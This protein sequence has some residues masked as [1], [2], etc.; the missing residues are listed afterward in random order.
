MK[1][2]ISVLAVFLP[3]LVACQG[4][5]V[6]GKVVNEQG[7]AVAGATVVLKGSD[8]TTFSDGGG[9]FEFRNT[10]VYDTLVVSAVGYQTQ[11]V[12]NSE[13]GLITVVLERKATSLQE[14]TVST[15]YQT[16]PRER[17][18]GSFTRIDTQH[19][20]QQVSSDVLSRLEAIT[21]GLSVSRR[22][23]SQGQVS[24]RGLSTIRGPKDP[25]VVVDNFPWEGDIQNLNPA[26]VESITVLKDAA[27]ASI[28]GS[29]A[30]NGVIVITTRKG[31]YGQ[32]L[33]VE[34]L[35]ALTVGDKPD[36]MAL[37]TM[38]P[39][40]FVAVER[41]LFSRGYRF[42]DTASTSRPPFSPV[43]EILFRQRRG[44]LTAAEAEAQLAAL[45]GHDVRRDFLEHAYRPPLKQQY[46][47]TLR[48]GSAAAAWALSA[49][50]DHH[51]GELHDAY[52]RLT[53]RLEHTLK[54]S[55]R[56]TLSAGAAYTDTR[57]EG[58]RPGY[59]DVRVKGGV[60]PPYTRL[61]GE[62][63]EAL[64]L[65]ADYRQ[66][67]IDTAGGGR[68]LPW[69]YY[70]LDDWR[71]GHQ[72][73]GGSDL[74][75]H[76]G[77]NY[78]LLSFL[79]LEVKYAYQRGA[80]EQRQH[81][82]EDSYFA[83]DLVNTFSQLN[84]TTGAV[85]YRV[86]RGGILDRTEG[87]L[88]VHNLRGQLNIDRGWGA[89]RLTGIVGAEQRETANRGASS[90]LYG[91]SDDILVSTPV[92]PT[93]TYPTFIRGSQAFIPY[94]Q[95][96]SE[97]LNR[98]VS[99]YGN[100]AW[101]LRERYTLSAS[102]RR[103]ASNLFGVR[104]ID[105]WTPLWSAGGSWLLSGERF[106]RLA[107][108]PLLRLRLT[109]GY[110]G[111]VDPSL[112][113]V[114]TISYGNASPFTLG[115]T[116]QID[117]FYNPDLRW[118]KVRMLNGGLDFRARGGRLW[119]TVE[120]Y[121]KRGVD[122][123]G[124][125]PL[126]V[127]VGVGKTT[128]IKNVASM[129]GEGLDLELNTV[130]IEG[131]VRWEAQAILNWN[132]DEVTDYYLATRR[133][134]AFINGGQGVAGVEG[135]PVY[136]L[137]N[138]RW[139]GLDGATGDPMGLYKGVVSKDWAALTG[140]ATLLDDLVY[141]GPALPRLF[142]SLGNTLGWKGLSLTARV[143]YKLGYYFMRETIG[144]PALYAQSVGHSDYARRWQQPGDEARTF[145]PSMDY[146]ASSNR[147]A[148]YR[149]AEVHVRR[150]DHVRLNYVQLLYELR[151][152][153]WRRLPV[154]RLQWAVNL[155]DGGLLWAANKEGLDPD[156]RSDALPPRRS[157]ALSLK[158][159]F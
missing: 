106:Y 147:D 58:G 157:L 21:N 55:R 118:E 59:F 15:G 98:F 135:R 70:P 33:Q 146:P 31:R 136:S 34:F 75:T 68:L 152:E 82:G 143:T 66:P 112:S 89:H 102:A 100:A 10:T 78:R 42:S 64:P 1:R 95:S 103:D 149:R 116:A 92:D 148:F 28:W 26:D 144:Y 80:T 139:V 85:T 17:A 134:S 90:R 71:Y 109:Y 132:R 124:E 37:P 110:S 54:L 63:G 2:V 129:R 81:Y 77:L 142:G 131:A 138:Y 29:R 97:R 79:A 62:G 36:L 130:A 126:D 5:W 57:G 119:G 74:R 7:E 127:T 137:F 125:A 114:T 96:M 22:I 86:P 154:A 117:R 145:V 158:A 115:P 123:Y 107:A 76:V 61:A 24:I 35:S 12:P 14:V 150:G 101:T 32:P 60:L 43:Y 20:A 25:L 13:R 4:I 16:L 19:F 8:R 72:R 52:R 155:Q 40:D 120:Y 151:R 51:S 140:P 69:T 108:L 105:R 18:T 48:G 49:G 141:S 41:F 23:S 153:Q 39:A 133:G 73:R 3:F 9:R 46:A 27:A 111:N 50:Y 11:E 44:A 128:L 87:G 99:F 122:L 113:A 91:Y 38:A 156:Y 65:Y 45:A 30:G 83:R 88:T 47:L 159:F 6:Q 67:Y 53:T 56:A 121:R 94:P 104:T 84:R 93:V